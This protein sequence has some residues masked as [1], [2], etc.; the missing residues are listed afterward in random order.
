MRQILIQFRDDIHVANIDDLLAKCP[1]PD[2][3]VLQW[4]RANVP[5]IAI[6]HEIQCELGEDDPIVQRH[7]AAIRRKGR[8][9]RNLAIRNARRSAYTVPASEY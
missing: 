6:G 2:E 8:R 7:R 3:A 5:N 1:N 4:A 9:Q